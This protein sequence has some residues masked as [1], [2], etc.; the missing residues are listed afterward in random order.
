MQGY[1]IFMKTV[2]VDP[3]WIYKFNVIPR[4]ISEGILETE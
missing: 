4:R 1:I 2:I 3:K